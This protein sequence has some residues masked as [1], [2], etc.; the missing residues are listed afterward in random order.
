MEVRRKFDVERINRKEYLER[1]NNLK[2]KKLIKIVTGIRR[3]GK[4][5]ILEMFRDRLLQDGVEEKQ[6]IFINFEDYEN[7]ELRNPITYTST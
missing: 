1:L 6:I 5:T 3:C 7:K 4:S 2:H